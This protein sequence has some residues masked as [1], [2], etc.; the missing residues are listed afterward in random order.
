MRASLWVPGRK[1]K[2]CPAGPC[3]VPRRQVMR[4]LY[5]SLNGVLSICSMLSWARTDSGS[6]SLPRASI[7]LIGP[8]TA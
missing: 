3:A 4:I 5:S 7:I 6:A 1:V 2:F 8:P